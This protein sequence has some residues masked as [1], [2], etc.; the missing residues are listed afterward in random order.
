MGEIDQQFGKVTLTS[1]ER[2]ILGLLANGLSDSEIAEVFTLTIGTVKWYNRQLYNKLGVRN[3]TEAVTQAQQRGLVKNGS[4]SAAPVTAHN[5]ARQATAFIGRATELADIAQLLSDPTCRLLTLAGPGGIGKTRLAIQVATRQLEN[6][7]DGVYF[8][9]LQ[10]IHS[11]DHIIPTIASAI[12][13]Q[14]Y[15]GDQPQR[16]LLNY[17]R[18]KQQLL[19]LD[20][21]EHLLSGVDILSNILADAVAVKVIVTSREALNLQEE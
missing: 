21:F 8:V 20:N 2:E 12:N 6:Y 19:V 15:A 13:F 7:P 16:Q 1:R 11:P 10:P 17:L 4:P 18:N 3:R 14:F 9:A 5:L